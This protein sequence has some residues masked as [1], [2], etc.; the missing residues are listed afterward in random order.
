[1]V[2]DPTVT[3]KELTTMKQNTSMRLRIST[4]T[5]ATGLLYAVTAMAQPNGGDNPNDHG[6]TSQNEV[7]VVSTSGGPTLR[8]DD[9]GK[10]WRLVNDQDADR[11]RNQI[12]RKLQGI[13]TGDM[14]AN[15]HVSVDPSGAS[16]TVEYEVPQAGEVLLTLHDSRGVEVL[17]VPEYAESEGPRR[18]TLDVT[19]LIAGSYFLRIVSNGAVSGA[20][21]LIISR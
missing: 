12:G 2:T 20:G 5:F 3:N 21:K 19:S 15:T 4:L 6:G 14:T 1:M 18:T 17:R 13:T 11:L 9:G 8:S 10:T 16:A 7:T